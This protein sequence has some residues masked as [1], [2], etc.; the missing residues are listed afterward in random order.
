MFIEYSVCIYYWFKH[1]EDAPSSQKTKEHL[2]SA[3]YA[4][5]PS[6]TK[7]LLRK[8]IAWAKLVEPVHVGCQ[9]PK[10]EYCET[11]NDNFDIIYNAR[12]CFV[13]NNKKVFVKKGNENF[14]VTMGA[15]DGA[16]I[17]ELVGLYMLQQ[18][19]LTYLRKICLAFI[20]TMVWQ[21]LDIATDRTNF[22]W[23]K[24]W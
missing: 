7:D 4:C 8:T 12:K 14:D 5:H 6:I 19:L 9:M 24:I 2:K 3:E 17:A 21:C 22:M 16:E 10:N 23:S 15:W 1:I 20:E 18:C 13:F 11:C